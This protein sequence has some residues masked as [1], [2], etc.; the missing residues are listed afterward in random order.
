MLLLDGVNDPMS[1]TVYAR[2]DDVTRG[3]RGYHDTANAL[4]YASEEQ[5]LV[6]G[7]C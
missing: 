7:V 1:S 6:D 2:E 4:I 5:R 3:D